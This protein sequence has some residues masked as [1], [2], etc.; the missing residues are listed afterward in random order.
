MAITVPREGEIWKL[1]VEAL[2]AQR[3]QDVVEE[4][5]KGYQGKR[6]VDN[7]GYL[8]REWLGREALEALRTG[9][10]LAGKEP[11]I[12]EE[13]PNAVALPNGHRSHLLRGLVQALPANRLPVDLVE[14]RLQLDL[15]M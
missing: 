10:R 7:L 2:G 5:L 11:R 12:F 14:W 6:K 1:A 3:L 13:N 8:R 15:G 9:Q 4:L